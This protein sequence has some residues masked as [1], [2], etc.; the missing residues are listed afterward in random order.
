[1]IIF[2][3]LTLFGFTVYATGNALGSPERV[4]ENLTY[5]AQVQLSCTSSLTVITSTAN[6]DTMVCSVLLMLLLLF[7][8]V[9]A[10]GRNHP[11]LLGQTMKVPA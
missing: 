2:I 5:M 6:T 7:V 9:L 10:L 11:A 3:T 4:Y 1:M 8:P